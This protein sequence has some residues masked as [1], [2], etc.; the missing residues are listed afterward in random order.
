MNFNTFKEVTMSM[1]FT[2]ELSS[3]SK[4][5][6]LTHR[7]GKTRLTLMNQELEKQFYSLSVY[8]INI[9]VEKEQ[10][11]LEIMFDQIKFKDLIK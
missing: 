8:L 5:I 7:E 11:R 2:M 10:E 1:G 4:I 9:G 6:Y 3:D